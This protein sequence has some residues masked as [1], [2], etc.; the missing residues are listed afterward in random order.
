MSSAVQSSN[1]EELTDI[2]ALTKDL[3]TLVRFRDARLAYLASSALERLTALRAAAAK[4][5]FVCSNLLNAAPLQAE[6]EFT[7]IYHSLLDRLARLTDGLQE[8]RR[9]QRLDPNIV[10]AAVRVQ[11]AWRTLKERD[12]A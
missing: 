12:T 2:R 4:G 1:R 7:E 3:L 10:D 8:N 11:E 6:R 9:W 5:G